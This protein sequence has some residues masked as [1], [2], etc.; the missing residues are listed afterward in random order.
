MAPRN[1]MYIAA[2]CDMFE[3]FMYAMAG[4][5]HEGERVNQ[6]M[7]DYK[8]KEVKKGYKI[9]EFNAIRNSVIKE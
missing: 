9:D 2:L 1:V 4:E 7:V 6:L 5:E 8:K 3:S